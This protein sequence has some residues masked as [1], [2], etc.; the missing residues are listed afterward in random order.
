ME[1]KKFIDFKNCYDECERD[2]LSAE[3]ELEDQNI[4][5][6]KHKLEKVNLISEKNRIE[7]QIDR[8]DEETEQLKTNLKNS[9]Y[10]ISDCKSKLVLIQKDAGKLLELYIKHKNNI[11]DQDRE[12]FKNIKILLDEKGSS[13]NISEDFKPRPTGRIVSRVDA[14]QIADRTIQQAEKERIELADKEAQRTTGELDNVPWQDIVPVAELPKDIKSQMVLTSQETEERLKKIPWA[15]YDSNGK[16]KIVNPPVPV[17]YMGKELSDEVKNRLS[18]FKWS[19]S[20]KKRWNFGDILF[21]SGVIEKKT[22]SQGFVMKHRPYIYQFLEKI[23]F[24][25]R[26]IHKGKWPKYGYFY[27]PKS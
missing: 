13:G 9:Q 17:G 19:E 5:F 12:F 21:E 25:R 7:M 10:Y 20:K 3:K 2:L 1:Y 15:R 8:M 16:D 4:K 27:N 22:K 26:L 14:L 6:N 24:E 11:K 18:T 23:G